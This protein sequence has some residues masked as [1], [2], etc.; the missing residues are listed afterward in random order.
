M[1]HR[2]NSVPS[3]PLIRVAIFMPL[4]G[5]TLRSPSVVPLLWLRAA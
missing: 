5:S 4:Y 2:Q 3:D 1:S